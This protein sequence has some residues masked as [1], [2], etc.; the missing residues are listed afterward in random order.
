MANLPG[1]NGAFRYLSSYIAEGVAESYKIEVTD[2]PLEPRRIRRYPI[3]PDIRASA[4]PVITNRYP[5]SPGAS[6]SE[7]DEAFS[8]ATL[9]LPAAGI[10]PARISLTGRRVTATTPSRQ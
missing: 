1:E 2:V 3:A 6:I 9:S 4:V 5:Q 10:A 8:R 7:G